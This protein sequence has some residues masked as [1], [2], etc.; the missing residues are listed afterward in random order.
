M[1]KV[2]KLLA[3]S[4]LIPLGLPASASAADDEMKWI[5]S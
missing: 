3:K 1:K 2:I 5:I 4:I